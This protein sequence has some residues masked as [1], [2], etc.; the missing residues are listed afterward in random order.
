MNCQPYH[1]NEGCRRTPLPGVDG[2]V[3]YLNVRLYRSIDSIQGPAMVW[4][5]QY[6]MTGPSTN[7][8]Q[9]TSGVVEGFT[10]VLIAAWLKANEP[11]GYRRTVR[12]GAAP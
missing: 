9:R 12:F 3:A 6:V 2:C 11:W 1:V 5:R 4:E 10:K 7:F 8:E